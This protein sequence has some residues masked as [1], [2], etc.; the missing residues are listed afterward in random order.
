MAMDMG[1]EVAQK[2]HHKQLFSPYGMYL[3]ASNIYLVS[4]TQNRS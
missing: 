2:I 3:K 4:Q 1:E